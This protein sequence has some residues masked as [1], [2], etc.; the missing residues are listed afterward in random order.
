MTEKELEA[1]F[2]I[3]GVKVKLSGFSYNWEDKKLILKWVIEN[4]KNLKL[5]IL[6]KEYIKEEK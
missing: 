3:N 6:K 1:Q 5:T 2:E 4:N